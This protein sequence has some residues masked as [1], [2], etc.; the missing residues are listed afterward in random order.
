MLDMMGLKSIQMFQIIK[1]G[2]A[3]TSLPSISGRIA[4]AGESV[5]DGDTILTAKEG[6]IDIRF[7]GVNAAERGTMLEKDEYNDIFNIK[8]NAKKETSELT[9]VSTSNL[10][11]YFS[12]PFDSE[13]YSDAE[14]FKDT[15]GEEILENHLKR[16]LNKRTA[17]NHAHHAENARIELINMV[18]NDMRRSIKS[19]EDFQLY[20]EFPYEPID[21]YGR[22]LGWVYYKGD[23]PKEDKKDGI[24][25]K[26]RHALSYNEKLL[27]MGCVIPYFIWPNVSPLGE[28]NINL[29]IMQ[30]LPYAKD[31]KKC[32][33]ADDI[34]NQTLVLCSGGQAV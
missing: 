2:S 13:K 18:K 3:Y 29:S 20:I 33:E 12:N 31:F 23:K 5:I 10:E 32:I 8:G 22:F 26:I 15:L 25:K 11:E 17:N 19:P 16:I 24:T 6:L 30:S 27:K 1:D 21:T 9:Y 14:D 4:T 34:L 7:C 28:T